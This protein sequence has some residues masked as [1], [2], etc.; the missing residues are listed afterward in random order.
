MKELIALRM[1]MVMITITMKKLVLDNHTDMKKT[2]SFPLEQ[3][4]MMRV[5]PTGLHWRKMFPTVTTMMM[6]KKEK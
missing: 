2:I 4:Q 1:M 6:K 3:T 5:I